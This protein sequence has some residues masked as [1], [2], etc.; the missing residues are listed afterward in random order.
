MVDVSTAAV[1]EVGV[2]VS[3]GLAIGAAPKAV[4]AAGAV[5]APVPPLAIANVPAIVIVPELVIGPPDVVRPVVPPETST[6]M[7]EPPPVMPRLVLASDAFVAPVPPLAIA[8]V[9]P[10][11][12]VPDVVTGLPDVVSPVAP[13]DTATLVTVP[14]PAGVT[15]VLAKAASR[16]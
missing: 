12:M 6:L 7:T 14:P 4:S 3:A 5:I 8:S 9:P 11:V 16:F 15:A 2:P 1:V 13:P 10:S